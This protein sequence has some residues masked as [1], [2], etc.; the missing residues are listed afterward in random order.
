[1]NGF[2]NFDE[3]GREYLLDPT[4]YLIVSW[5]SKIKGQGHSRPSRWNLANIISH[6]L[7]EKSQ[8]NLRWI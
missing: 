6:E 8:W 1:M 5:K 4:D 7:L 2:N 3:T